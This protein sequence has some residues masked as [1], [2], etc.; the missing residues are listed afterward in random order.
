MKKHLR[1]IAL[2]GCVALSMGVT[3]LYAQQPEKKLGW[4]LSAQTYTFNRFT[5]F[6]AVDKTL[7][8][9]LN[10]VEA[11]NGQELGGGIEGS[12]DY[13][14]D[15]E[16]RKAILKALKKK[17][18]KLY[19]FGVVNGDNETEWKQ[20][21][22]FAKAMGIK[23]INSEPKAEFMPLIGQLA[24]QYKI[25]VGIHNHPEPSHYWSPQVV[26][27]AIAAANSEYV[28]ACADIGHWVR[29][30]LD[31]V[32]S[33]KQY[34]GHLVS[35]HFKDLAEKS[36]KT[37]DVHW[38]TGVCNVKGVIAEL[39]RQGFK[40]VISAEYEHNW[41]NNAGDV[42]QSVANFREIVSGL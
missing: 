17:G 22:E 5:F 34:E 29:S 13:K 32:E 41:E 3:K 35:L 31:P 14:M 25:K 8:A 16:K 40:G 42:A 27:D 33:L 1:L 9:G 39:K 20:L 7:S 6:E 23:V 24:T 15:A 26:L 19:A 37:H 12:M 4:Y 36:S 2:M 21:F 28:G 18:V 11:F 38:G 30:G 10:T